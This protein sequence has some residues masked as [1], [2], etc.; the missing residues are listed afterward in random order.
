MITVCANMWT[1]TRRARCS[2]C[3]KGRALLWPENCWYPQFFRP[4]RGWLPNTGGVRAWWSPVRAAT[5]P[6]S[7]AWTISKQHERQRKRKEPSRPRPTIRVSMECGLSQAAR[8]RDL[9]GTRKALTH[10]NDS[11]S[12]GSVEPN[13]RS[14]CSTRTTFGQ[15]AI[16]TS[17]ERT[18]ESDKDSFVLLVKKLTWPDQAGIVWINGL[19][20]NGWDH[21]GSQ[22]SQ[23]KPVVI[24]LLM[25]LVLS[26]LFFRLEWLR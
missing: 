4:D 7:A 21:R 3:Y 20:H 16:T 5:T 26:L 10:R 22:V 19:T 15:G 11:R 25:Q 18:P 2:T 1:T 12:G 9:P 13:F 17:M 24:I 14:S 6:A 8:N 23:K